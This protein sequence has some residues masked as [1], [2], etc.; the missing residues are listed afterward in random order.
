MDQPDPRPVTMYKRWSLRDGVTV[1]EV[2]AFARQHIQPA[3]QRLSPDV[4]LGLEMAGDGLSIVAVQRWTSGGA[5]DAATSGERYAIWWA[6]NE[7]TL[8]LWDQLVIF[9]D[10]WKSVEVDLEHP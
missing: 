4:T 9:A 3:Y 10:E 7:R 2:A 5:R 8:E 6:A 1:E